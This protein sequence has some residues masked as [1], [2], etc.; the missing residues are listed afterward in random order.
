MSAGNPA[1]MVCSHSISRTSGDSVRKSA[2]GAS[3]RFDSLHLI[4]AALATYKALVVLA[5][6]KPLKAMTSAARQG[7]TC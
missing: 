7:L 1:A 2:T 5:F 6:H 4:Q 3:H